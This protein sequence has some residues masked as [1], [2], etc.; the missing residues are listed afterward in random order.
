MKRN[1]SKQTFSK[2]PSIVRALAGFLAMALLVT[3]AVPVAAER[4]KDISTISGLRDNQLVGYGLVI[5]LNGTGDKNKKGSTTQA[6]V[7]MLRRMGIN[8]RQNDLKPKNVAAVVVTADMPTIAK[9]GTRLDVIVSS[10]SDAK[11]LQGGTLLLTPLKGPDEQI[12]ALA[13]GAVSVGG[14]VAHGGGTSVSKNHPTVGRVPEGAVI[15]RE[16]PMTLAESSGIDLILHT[17]D[18][19][20]VHSVMKEIDS[21]LGGAYT[22]AGGP[23]AVHLS[24]PETYRGRI[25]ELLA[26]IEDIDVQTDV[27]SKIVINE[28]TG[29]VVLGER[30]EVSPVAIAHGSLTV[31]IK[32]E[33]EVSQPSPFSSTGTTTVTENAEVSVEE[34]RSR[35]SPVSGAN[36]GE[37]VRALNSLGVTPRDLIAIL[38]ALKVSGALKAELEIL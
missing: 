3:G 22:K 24:V 5:G 14:F 33:E 4:I 19:S 11:S 6:L 36:L 21:F 23:G 34:K 32:T 18:F 37:V 20:T 25:V 7:N 31:Q 17:P 26:E 12:Y 10:I 27:P 30:V 9:A 28:K 35:L 16:V 8:L 15:E 38:Q 29:T 2:E 13:Q 1:F